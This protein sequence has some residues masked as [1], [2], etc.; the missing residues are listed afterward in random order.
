MLTVLRCDKIYTESGVIDGYI[1][2]ENKMI[3]DICEQYDGE[4]DVDFRGKKIIPGLIDTHNHGFLG[5][6]MRTSENYTIDHETAIQGYLKGLVAYGVTGVFPTCSIDKIASIATFA[7]DNKEKGA[8]ILGIHSEGPWL[9]RVGE[10]GIKK[11]FIHPSKEIAEKMVNDGKG[12]LKLVSLS[13]EI[14]SIESVTRVMK[15]KDVTLAIAHTD[16]LYENVNKCIDQKGFRVMTHLGNAMTGLHHRDVGA[17]GAG[18]LNNNVYC[19]VICDFIHVCKEMVQ[20]MLSV[21]D[22]NKIIMIS[23]NSEYT[24]LPAGVYQGT[25]DK[26]TIEVGKDGSIHTET[27][28]IQGSSIPMIYGLKNLVQELDYDLQEVLKLSSKNCC[29]L[30]KL[31]NRGILKIG[32]Y[33]DIVVIDDDFTVECTYV[34][35]NLVYDN[36]TKIE[37]LQNKDFILKHKITQCIYK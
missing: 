17:I 1:I 9:N 13:P 14:E 2:L 15:D 34:E 11:G 25:D 12:Q 20:I 18:L 24:A 36:S 8:K 10:K 27:G 33:A 31:E 37:D 28:K 3:Q 26:T 35:G 6:P 5:Y 22:L 32:N 23:D 30:Y 19:E 21:K 16:Y 4:I 29:D 7:K